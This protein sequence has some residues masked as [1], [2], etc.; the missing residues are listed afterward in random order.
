MVK[1]S[2]SL[3]P[4]AL[5]VAACGLLLLIHGALVTTAAGVAALPASSAAPAAPSAIPPALGFLEQTHPWMGAVVGLLTL[6]LV[7]RITR[8]DPRPGLHRL[9]WFLLVLLVA[10]GGLGSRE[11]MAVSPEWMGTLHA[12]LAQVFFAGTAAIV[13]VTSAGWQ[14]DPDLVEDYGWPSLRSFAVT[15]PVLVLTQV[16]LGAGLRHKATGALS[17]LGFAMLVAL[18]ILIE[19]AFVIQQFPTHRVLRPAANWLL[20]ITCAQVF[21]GIGAFTMRTMEMDRTTALG[22]GTA[23]HVANGALTLAMSVVMSLQIRHIVMP[24]GSLSPA[25]TADPA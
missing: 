13:V 2:S 23:A 8:S 15:T 18:W 20:A 4:L 1:T 17:H 11:A 22:V 7:I 12:F 19:C 6:V 21:L 5:V 25:P 14:S 10:Q 24:K 9:G 16:F 3:F